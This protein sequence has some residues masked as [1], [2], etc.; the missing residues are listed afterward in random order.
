MDPSSQEKVL[1]LTPAMKDI[2]ALRCCCAEKL[3]ITGS[4][5]LRYDS[6]DRPLVA[7]VERGGS[8]S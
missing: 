5:E 6:S 2:K 4:F 3:G 8:N 1:K 7:M